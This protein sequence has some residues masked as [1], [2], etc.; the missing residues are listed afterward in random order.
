MRKILLLISTLFYFFVSPYESR[1]QGSQSIPNGSPT[2]P[3][4][5]PGPG[6]VYQWTNSNPSIGLS[7]SGTG[8]IPPFVATNYTGNPAT[9]VIEA[10]PLPTQFAYIANNNASGSITI[11][12]TITNQTLPNTI[13]PNND[14]VGVAVSP[15]GSRVYVTNY[16]SGT[17]SVI[18]TATNTEI[19]PPIPAGSSP[20]GV[21]VSPDGSTIY[22]TNTLLGSV[23]PINTFTGQALPGIAVRFGPKG[24]AI[25][26]D[27]SRL[28][29]ANSVDNSVSVINTSNNFTITIPTVNG[30]D[31]YGL[32]VSPDGKRVYVANVVS[33]NVTVID[34]VSN[35]VGDYIPVGSGPYTTAVSPDGSKVY[36]SNSGSLSGSGP[37]PPGTVSVIDPGNDHVTNTIPVGTGPAGMSFTP[38]GSELYVLNNGDNTASVIRTSDGTV[39]G[40]P[41]PVGQSPA[42]LGNFIAGG[43]GCSS[44]VQYTITVTPFT[45]PPVVKVGDVSGIIIACQG[46][47]S[48]TPN[49]L[50]VDV[51][52]NGL[53]D[54][55]IVTAPQNFEVSLSPAGS[56]SRTL[57][58]PLVGGKVARTQVYIRVAASAIAGAIPPASLSVASGP[59]STPVHISATIRPSTTANQPDDQTLKNG[60]TTKAINF[61]GTGDTYTWT[62]D[63]PGIG[64]PASGAGNIGAFKAVNT[65][66]APIT[67]TIK[68]TPVPKPLQYAY[69]ANAESYDVSV[70]NTETKSIEKTIPVDNPTASANPGPEDVAINP[71]G[72][73]VYV[74]NL[75][76]NNIS[77]IDPSTNT[78]IAKISFPGSPSGMCFSPDGLT[79]YVCCNTGVE[80]VNTITNTITGFI[81]VSDD[82]TDLA[83]SPDGA[84]LYVT[85]NNTSN[86]GSEFYFVSTVAGKVINHITVGMASYGVCVSPDGSRIYVANSYSN[87]VSVIDAAAQTIITSFAAGTG[88]WGLCLSPDG[89]VLYVTNSG[90]NPYTNVPQGSV[91][92]IDTKIGRLIATITVGLLPEGISITPDGS[93][94]YVANDFGDT[95]PDAVPG[96]GTVSVINTQTNKVI[97]T[98]NT[99]YNTISYGNFI[100]NVNECTGQPVTFTITVNPSP[101][102]P[103]PIPG[104]PVVIPNAFTPNGDG[105]NDNWDIQNIN[106]YANCSVQIFSRWGQKVFSSVGYGTPWDGTYKGSALPSGTYYYVINLEDGSKE[107]SG[108]VAVIR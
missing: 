2:E 104:G 56:F 45:L 31:P 107:L 73:R 93:E 66:N 94:V 50:E 97:K 83:I 25:S 101:V 3:I 22:V 108:Y 95:L 75:A 51:S 43:A 63:Q 80:V 30:K 52:G 42:S 88:P 100:T 7:A 5:F 6:C 78:V 32:S 61:T 23:T 44:T 70:I 105:I 24:I 58:L 98:I 38:D 16:G 85:E 14:P 1:A 59:S 60:Q 96:T 8:N 48:G 33:D 10:T 72:S 9:A 20:Y 62:N 53:T 82:P 77:V 68:V 21:V 29:V 19:M 27:G 67:A 41:I 18:S 15:D 34:A 57:T 76:A 106:A 91:S 90:E 81:P 65:G 69:V 74:S 84:T 102:L 86:I 87:N 12:N 71:D 92:V 47:A 4:I 54:D 79:L 28:Y 35:T 49:M 55:I 39:P 36:V 103:P 26:P 64:L 46:E 17:V 11:L 89:S 99:E 37:L 40:Q 13:S